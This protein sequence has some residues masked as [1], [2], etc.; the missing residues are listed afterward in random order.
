MSLWIPRNNG[1]RWK[2]GS[3]HCFRHDNVQ[4]GLAKRM[5]K[6]APCIKTHPPFQNRDGVQNAIISAVVRKILI[7]KSSEN[8]F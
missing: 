3:A 1:Q 4:V 2:A 6:K 5:I 7:N 8:I